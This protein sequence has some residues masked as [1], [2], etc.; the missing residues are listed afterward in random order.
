[1]SIEIIPSTRR[2]VNFETGATFDEP[3][4]RI[5][6]TDANGKKLYDWRGFDTE[7]DAFAALTRE[8]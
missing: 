4:F 5:V 3:C 1:M 2:A 7:A 8:G 6:E